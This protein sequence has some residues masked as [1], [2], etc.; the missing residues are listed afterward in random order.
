VSRA[1]V[2]A[3]F[4]KFRECGAGRRECQMLWTG[5]WEDP[6]TISEAVHSRHR[7]H[8][9]GFDVDGDWLNS[10]WLELATKKTGVRVQVHTHPGQAFHSAIDDSYSI[11]HL[12]GFL[13]LVIPNFGFGPPIFEDAYLAELTENGDWK[14]VTVTNRFEII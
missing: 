2:A 14:S 9:S 3:T 13:S 1:I 6:R 11:V 7:S 10:F 4:D 5:P 12:P 8:S